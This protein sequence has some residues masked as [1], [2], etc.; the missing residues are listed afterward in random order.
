MTWL[1]ELGV[2]NLAMAA[3]LALVAAIA[4]RCLRRPALT[5]ALWV[6]V[7]VKLV[8]PPF[9][10]L[11]MGWAIP[12]PVASETQREKSIWENALAA[13]RL[14]KEAESR[15][16]SLKAAS[17][18]VEAA[19][20]PTNLVLDR[21]PREIAKDEAAH[22]V[23]M[24]LAAF[25]RTVPAESVPEDDDENVG[26]APAASIPWLAITAGI[27]LGGS[28]VWVLLAGYRLKR[29]QTVLR[30]ALPAPASLLLEA[31]VM[32]ERLGI[33]C[34]DLVLVPGQLSPMLWV[35]GGQPRL[36]LPATLLERLT[37]DQC[38]AL[39]AHEMAHW[40]RGDHWVRRLQLIVLGLYWWCPLVWWAR[41][42]LEQAEEECCDAWVVWALPST[43][44]DYALALVETVDFLS[45]ADALLPPVASG[46]GQVHHLRRRLTM[47]LNGKTPRTLTFGGG[48]MVLGL[49]A[50]L[51]PWMPSW[52]QPPQETRA[53]G[54]QAQSEELRRD[55]QRRQQEL[56][57]AANELEL[58]QAELHRMKANFEKRQQDLRRA[59]AEMERAL[60]DRQQGE[61]RKARA[62]SKGDPDRPGGGE[63]GLP[64]DAAPK[65][66][67]GGFGGG[68]G[69]GPGAGFPGGGGGGFGPPMVADM[70]RRLESLEQ[71]VDEI[72]REIRNMRGFGPNAFPKGP[73][74]AGQKG[75]KGQ[76]GRTQPPPSPDGALFAP[77]PP[78]PALPP[79]S[80]PARPTDPFGNPLRRPPE[81]APDPSP[82]P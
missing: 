72:L 2:A 62:K 41:G 19:P 6:L 79:T 48:L 13:I 81:T 56:E 22:L 28:L 36:L 33:A 37:P 54:G 29:F 57:K 9:L 47:I 38:R 7:F 66:K 15:S 45:G 24:P 80:A 65:E 74:G 16:D 11:P 50:L 14:Q 69:F 30:H 51:L 5:H 55:L 60:Q 78:I 4:G 17:E 59:A 20:A 27:W 43:A 21:E 12:E 1:M 52:A 76:S 32:A 71:K 40:R 25:G 39:L 42:E 18:H 34:P 23:E 8:T 61:E 31:R 53:A 73:G 10:P 82:R 68:G 49:A 67:R 35:R 75:Q 63:G 58:M 26:T 44:R 3:L 64:R 70:G 46:I 77:V